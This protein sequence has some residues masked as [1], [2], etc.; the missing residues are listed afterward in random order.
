MVMSIYKF[1]Y[2]KPI[3]FS[4]CYEWIKEFS[5]NADARTEVKRLSALMASFR[6]K[7]MEVQF[8][9]G[10]LTSRKAMRHLT[11]ECVLAS[12]RIPY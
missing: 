1:E 7:G 11:Q 9:L 2:D 3:S 10:K 4:I 12:S 8:R 6:A 5:S